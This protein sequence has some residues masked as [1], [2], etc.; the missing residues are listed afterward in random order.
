MRLVLENDPKLFLVRRYGVGELEVSGQQLRA[1]CLL[2]AAG[3]V[4]D[5]P[6]TAP[7]SLD[8]AALEP[9]RALKPAVLV[10]GSHHAGRMPTALARSLEAQGTA[11]ECMEFGAACRTYNVLAAEYRPVVAALFP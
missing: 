1:P 9:I 10:V 7:E 3:I 11:V 4:A 8:A 5:W 6:A 2:S